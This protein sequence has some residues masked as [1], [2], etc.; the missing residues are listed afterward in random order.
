MESVK[1]KF[2]RYVAVDTMSDPDSPAQPST[3]KQ[4]VLLELLKKEL[5]EMGIKEEA[6]GG[7]E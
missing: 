4:F 2:L 7:K 6:Y 1:D 5:I 3:N